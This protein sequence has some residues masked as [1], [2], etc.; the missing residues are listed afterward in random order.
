MFLE[1]K[2][3]RGCK[4]IKLL[5][6]D[7]LF[8]PL[9]HSGW[10]SYP[11]VSDEIWEMRARLPVFLPSFRWCNAN[12]LKPSHQSS[13]KQEKWL[14]TSLIL[15]KTRSRMTTWTTCKIRHRV[16]T[17]FDARIRNVKRKNK[18]VLEVFK[19]SIYISLFE[20]C[21]SIK[22]S[23]SSYSNTFLVSAY[24]ISQGWRQLSRFPAKVTLVHA[25]ALLSVEKIVSAESFLS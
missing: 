22:F 1:V 5:T 6:Y 20:P 17:T 19:S 8:P 21:Q 3:S 4:I 15:A 2:P 25:R 14:G 13:R 11:V 10:N 12:S 18:N 23:C 7:H 16:F 9:R 24:T